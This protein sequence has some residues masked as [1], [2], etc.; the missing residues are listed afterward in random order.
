M[1]AQVQTDRRISQSSIPREMRAGVYRG[2]GRVVS[3][4]VPVPEIQSGEILIRI[5][6]CGI[7]G[8]DV[9]K[10]KHDLVRPPQILGHE[11]AGTI[12]KV[13]SGVTPWAAGDRVVSF[14]HIPCGTCF[15]C[16]R[17]LFSQCPQYKKT[18]VTA[19]FEPNGGG[20]AQYVRVMAHI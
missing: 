13:G 15:Y 17:Q 9:K 1:N 2:S 18:G 4:T 8:T 14:H 10:V 19:G 6:A 3:E 20:F 11:M 7:C 16:A 5:A 12:V